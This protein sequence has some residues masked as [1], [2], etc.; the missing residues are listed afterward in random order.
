MFEYI[1]IMDLYIHRYYFIVIVPLLI[2]HVNTFN[3]YI[4]KGV[5]AANLIMCERPSSHSTD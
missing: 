4:Y 1:F 2:S 5:T 3:K